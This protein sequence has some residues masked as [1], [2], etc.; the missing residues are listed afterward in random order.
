MSIWFNWPFKVVYAAN[1]G[2]RDSVDKIMASN[3]SSKEL[4]DNAPMDVKV[5]QV[6]VHGA[7]SSLLFIKT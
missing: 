1:A 3:Y 4:E 6:C 5:V 7:V 2:I